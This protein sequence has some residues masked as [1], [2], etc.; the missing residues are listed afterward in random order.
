MFIWFCAW[1]PFVRSSPCARALPWFPWGDLQNPHTIA[2]GRLSA[3]RPCARWNRYCRLRSAES[4]SCAGIQ[5]PARAD[6][7]CAACAKCHKFLET[8]PGAL[9]GQFP[10]VW[11]RPERRL[12]NGPLTGRT[13][14]PFRYKGCLLSGLRA[15]RFS[16][17][18]YLRLSTR[19]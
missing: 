12:Q 16:P 17:A 9:F 3:R 14:Y 2:P 5:K 18:R 13:A 8:T 7:I 4:G 15:C 10:A 6:E 1:L 19:C 11:P